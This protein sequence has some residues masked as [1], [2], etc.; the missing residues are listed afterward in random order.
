MEKTNNKTDLSFEE[1]LK[2]LEEIVEKLSAGGGNLEE[3][4]QLYESGVDYLKECRK[5]LVAAET[6]IITLSKELSQQSDSNQNSRATQE[7]ENG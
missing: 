5:K 7:E 1:A 4:V 6:R 2:L 3:L